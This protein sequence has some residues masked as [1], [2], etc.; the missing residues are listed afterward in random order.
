MMARLASNNFLET[1]N[2]SLSVLF[3]LEVGIAWSGSSLT[4]D[5]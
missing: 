3:G 4:I 2:R 1:D 5:A